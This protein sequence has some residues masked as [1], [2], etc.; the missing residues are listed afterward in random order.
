MLQLSF[1]FLERHLNR[2]KAVRLRPPAPP[3]PQQSPPQPQPRA[4]RLMPWKHGIAVRVVRRPRAR[5]YLLSLQ[6]DGTARLVIPRRGTEA[7]AL[8]FLERSEGWLLRRLAQWRS[9]HAA[10]QP[11][12][13]GARFLFRG[14]EVALHVEPDGGRARACPSPTRPS[15]CRARWPITGPPCMRTCAGWAS[16]SCRRARASWRTRTASPSGR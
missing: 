16:G 10:R 6:P 2:L 12:R 15:W 7:E 5:R 1:D 8:G 14:E 13:H 3:S 11:W 9:R 4:D